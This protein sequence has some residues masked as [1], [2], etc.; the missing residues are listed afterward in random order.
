MMNGMIDAGEK[1]LLFFIVEAIAYM[2]GFFIV[3]CG[4]HFENKPMKYIGW[5]IIAIA[6]FGGMLGIIAGVSK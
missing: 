3:W 4:K 1:L 5:I 6:T 2:I